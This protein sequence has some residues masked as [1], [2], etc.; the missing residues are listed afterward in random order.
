MLETTQQSRSPSPSSIAQ[1][2]HAECVEFIRS[3][4]AEADRTTARHIA[5]VVTE[6]CEN[7]HADRA[8]IW[9]ALTPSPANRISRTTRT[10]ANCPEFCPT[11]SR[12]YWLAVSGSSGGH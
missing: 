6:V 10:A 11:D 1:D 4:I 9:Q 7:G 5:A 2:A 8:A 3:A 12:G